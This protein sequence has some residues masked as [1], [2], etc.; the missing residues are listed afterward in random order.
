MTSKTIALRVLDGTIVV[1][2]GVL[3]LS[4]AGLPLDWLA[5]LIDMSG[6][7]LRGFAMFVVFSA[8]WLMHAIAT[9]DSAP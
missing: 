3:I 7:E 5:D 2:T 4:V 1:V 9:S 8:L 6:R